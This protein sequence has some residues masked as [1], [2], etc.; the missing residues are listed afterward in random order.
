MNIY[1]ENMIIYI[2]VYLRICLNTS[3]CRYIQIH[4]D[5]NRCG[6]TYTTYYSLRL[7]PTKEKRG[8]MEKQK[9][10]RLR[11]L[12]RLP[13]HQSRFGYHNSSQHYIYIFVRQYI[14]ICIV[15][16]ML[17]YI[18]Y[19]YLFVDMVYIYIYKIHMIINKYFM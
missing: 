7:P 5:L 15:L 14:Y 9:A 8:N 16:K 1:V 3:L 17:V 6:H 12:P 18:T 10:G 2:Y 11:N 13:P 19:I 4:T